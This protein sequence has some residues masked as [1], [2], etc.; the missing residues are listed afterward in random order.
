MSEPDFKLLLSAGRNIPSEKWLH[1]RLSPNVEHALCKIITMNKEQLRKIISIST[2]Q[3]FS[4]NV[5]LYTFLK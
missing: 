1:E 2:R 5:R 4:L 3:V